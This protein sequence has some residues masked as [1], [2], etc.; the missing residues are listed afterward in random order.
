MTQFADLTNQEFLRNKFDCSRFGIFK[1]RHNLTDT[2]TTPSAKDWT[3]TGIVSPVRDQGQCEAG[4]AISSVGAVEAAYRKKYGIG[5][6]LS[7][8]Q[9]LDCSTNNKGC[10]GGAAANAFQYNVER[11]LNYRSFYP[12]GG[13]QGK[14]R[15]EPLV[16]GKLIKSYGVGVSI[17]ENKLKQWVGSIGPVTVG[18]HVTNSFAFYEEGVYSSDECGDTTKLVFNSSFKCGGQDLNH[19]MLVVGYGIEDGVPYWLIQNSWGTD[20]GEKGYIKVEMGK[21]MCGVAAYA[22]YPILW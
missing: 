14:C 3:K 15:Y 4:W 20:W 18:F 17:D 21:N 1:G 10:D 11:K 7:E 13:T 6:S 16:V 19:F 22:A 9:L 8:Q 5:I 2:T 12:Y